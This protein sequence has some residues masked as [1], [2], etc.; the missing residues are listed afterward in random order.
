MAV[1]SSTGYK[2]TTGPK[3]LAQLNTLLRNKKY[4]SVFILCDENTLLRCMPMLIVACPALQDAQ[5]IELEA[6]E[7]SKTLEV[8]GMV[9]QTLAEN[10]AGRDALLL[11][12]GGGVVSD[13]GGF[14]ASA[15]KRGI[16]FINVPTSL[17]AMADA[18]V[19]GKT[20]I[21]FG[22]YKN[23]IGTFAQPNGVFVFPA[24]LQTLPQRHIANG[25]AEIYKIALVSDKTFW[26]KLHRSAMNT[27]AE[28]D[29]AKSIALKNKI[30]LKDPFDKSVR[31]ALN[32]GH[33][34]GHALEAQRLGGKNELLH[35]EAILAGMVAESHMAFQK[36]LITKK[37]LQE[38]TE[39]LF[40]QLH[41]KTGKLNF[42]D[43]SSY[44]INDKKVTGGKLLFSLPNGIG[45]CAID[46]PVSEKQIKV[47]LD[48][49]NSFKH[50]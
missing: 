42:D 21:D 5:V 37:E 32:F 27:V 45:K 23:M 34:I 49:F 43:L 25:M 8:C 28:T 12:L 14:C 15:Y 48:F 44:L 22:G 10:G 24:F 36:K 4:S 11:N 3:S 9:W 6:G 20:G 30:V 46:V 47:A 40:R 35:G 19:G 29:I 13:L 31:K 50:D 16:D 7:Q 18:S 26:Q 39:F 38:V 17:L 41:T 33:T 2:V 1:I